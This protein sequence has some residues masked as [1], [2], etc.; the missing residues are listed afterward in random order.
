M[1]PLLVSM[2]R[3][4][5]TSIGRQASTLGAG[6]AAIAAVDTESDAAS[7]AASALVRMAELLMQ[8]PLDPGRDEGRNVAAHHGDLLHQPGSDRLVGWVGHQ[9][10]GFDP[11]VELLV[12]RR[13]LEFVLVI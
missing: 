8:P 9:E 10:D 7:A 12:H 11:P 3:V 2:T 13:H 1:R 6:S 5:A 4:L